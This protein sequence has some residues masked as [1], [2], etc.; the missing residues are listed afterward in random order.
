MSG[1][2]TGY[3][4][5]DATRV[6]KYSF[7]KQ[8]VYSD[9]RTAADSAYRLSMLQEAS[10]EHIHVPVFHYEQA[11]HR[12]TIESEFIKGYLSFDIAKV[13]ED[14]INSDWT[15]TD[16]HPSNFITC[17]QT[18]KIYIVDLECY[19]YVPDIQDRRNL[20]IRYSDKWPIWPWPTYKFDKDGI[21]WD[22]TSV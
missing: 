11:G 9:I 10:F 17:K 4:D 15:F 22:D 16:P 8:I 18:N 2:V 1:N 12:L 20:W 19:E 14:C 13:Y 5:K 6:T 21:V 3:V 7:T